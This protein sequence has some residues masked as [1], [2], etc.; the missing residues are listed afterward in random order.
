VEDVEEAESVYVARGLSISEEIAT[1]RTRIVE[2]LSEASVETA[3][4]GEAALGF[5]TT[6]LRST[7]VICDDQWGWIT[8]TLP[9]LRATETMSM[10][11]IEAGGRSLVRA[12]VA[13]FDRVWTIVSR[14]GDV[15]MIHQAD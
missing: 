10:E 11:L 9:P 2:A 12:C 3:S 1:T 14:R 13:H 4:P 7:L 5:Y 6:H 15:T 8:I